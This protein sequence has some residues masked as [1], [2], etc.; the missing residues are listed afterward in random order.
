MSVSFTEFATN[1]INASA[2][3]RPAPQAVRSRADI[4]AERLAPP[5]GVDVLAH[6]DLV[7]CAG[8]VIG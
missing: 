5:R 4:L 2:S 3:R 1:V 8:E 6:E 7:G